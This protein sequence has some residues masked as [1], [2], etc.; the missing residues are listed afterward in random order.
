MGQGSKQLLPFFFLLFDVDHPI[1][2]SFPGDVIHPFPYIREGTTDGD[3]VQPVVIRPRGVRD[4]EHE[5]TL[6]V[7]EPGELGSTRR[8]FGGTVRK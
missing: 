4:P 3:A 8:R 5:L 7:R 6:Y 1:S 2:F